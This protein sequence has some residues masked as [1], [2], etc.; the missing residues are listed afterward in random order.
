MKMKIKVICFAFL[1]IFGLSFAGDLGVVKDYYD[2]YILF[3]PSQAREYGMRVTNDQEFPVNLTVEITDRYELTRLLGEQS[4][5]LEPYEK[6]SL[7]FL[8]QAPQEFYSNEN[9]IDFLFIGEPLSNEGMGEGSLI[10]TKINKGIRIDY[11]IEGEALLEEEIVEQEEY[12]DTVEEV[13]IVEQQEIQLEEAEDI[14]V[15]NNTPKQVVLMQTEEE[16]VEEQDEEFSI[17]QIVGLVMLGILIIVGGAYFV[18]HR[19]P[20]EEIEKPIE[21]IKK[22]PIQKE[23]SDNEKRKEDLAEKLKKLKRL[24]D[25]KNYG[26]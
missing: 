8:L 2:E 9:R 24:R 17:F 25:D 21:V 15:Y 16:P 4:Y 19:N 26:S 1:L 5:I 12:I 11:K 20:K 7:K 10:R 3:R 23:I 6:V 22:E 18:T 13:V 14:K